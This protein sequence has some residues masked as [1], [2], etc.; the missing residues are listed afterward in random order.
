MWYRL[1]QF[2]G[3]YKYM[4]KCSFVCQKVDRCYVLVAG[5][6][7]DDLLLYKHPTCNC[8]Y[9]YNLSFFFKLS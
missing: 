1:P 8:I 6:L 4:Y 2:V 3:S 7:E 5:L 9:M